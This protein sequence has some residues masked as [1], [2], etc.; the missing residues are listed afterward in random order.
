MVEN[1]GTGAEGPSSWREWMATQLRQQVVD[2]Q[3]LFQLLVDQ[4]HTRIDQTAASQLQMN[5]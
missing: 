1:G 5:A 4:Q 3:R 2:Q